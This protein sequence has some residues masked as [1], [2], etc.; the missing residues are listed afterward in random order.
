MVSDRCLSVLYVCDDGVLWPN[1][2]MDQHTTWYGG[3]PRPTPHCFRRGPSSPSVEQPHPEKGAQQPSPTIRLMSIVA[4]ARCIKMPLC[5]AEVGLSPG[6]IVLDGDPAP[7]ERGKAPP[8]TF[9]PM[10]IVAKRLDAPG[11]HLM[12]R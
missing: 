12:R 10:C 4:M 2:W 9:R 3:T 8:S 1:C 11:Y 5:T 7:P 6:H